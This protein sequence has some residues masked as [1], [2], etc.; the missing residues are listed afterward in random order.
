[1]RN[2]PMPKSSPEACIFNTL[3]TSIA[4]PSKATRTHSGMHWRGLNSPPNVQ[5]LSHHPSSKLRT[6]P[7]SPS[8]RKSRQPTNQPCRATKKKQVPTPY[9]ST[10]RHSSAVAAA[11]ALTNRA[12]VS[13]PPFASPVNLDTLEPQQLAQV[14]KQLEEELEHLTSSF[15]Q[16]HGAQ[17]KFKEC[18]RCV[19]ARAADS[20]GTA[21]NS[22]K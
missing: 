9:Y 16:L 10:I 5:N 1:M 6:L 11:A 20:K 14:K 7:P 2:C 12:C 13:C 3:A 18:L 19:Q 22:N 21:P 8:P 17:N 15:A 4:S